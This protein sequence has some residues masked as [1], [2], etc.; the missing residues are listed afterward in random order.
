VALIS[1]LPGLRLPICAS[2]VALAYD[3]PVARRS[4]ALFQTA[5][6]RV[7]MTC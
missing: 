2:A 4:E 7:V 6:R 5:Q 3:S 1:A